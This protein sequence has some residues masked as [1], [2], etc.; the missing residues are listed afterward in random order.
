[1]Q[2]TSY[3]YSWITSVPLKLNSHTPTV[4]NCKLEINHTPVQNFK[5]QEMNQ[6]L[7]PR[8]PQPER[9]CILLLI[10]R[11]HC[12]GTIYLL[13]L[14]R[15]TGQ[16][17]EFNIELQLGA[18]LIRPVLSLVGKQILKEAMWL[19]LS[20]FPFPKG[21]RGVGFNMKLTTWLSPRSPV[22]PV[23]FWGRAVGWLKQSLLGSELIAVW[24]WSNYL[25]PLRLSFLNLNNLGY[26][27]NWYVGLLQNWEN[28]YIAPT[29][30]SAS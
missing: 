8:L 24:P 12:F 26:C 22:Y 28:P 30:Y 13:S 21:A 16:H 9:M 15:I 29:W 18:Q 23:L 11:R 27:I 2:K 14:G 19:A 17:N 20:I 3:T 6:L 25:T 1:M 7:L 5:N 10:W 4:V